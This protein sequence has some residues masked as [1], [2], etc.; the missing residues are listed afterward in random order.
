[1]H[2]KY[3]YYTKYI[4]KYLRIYKNR[5]TKHIYDTKELTIYSLKTV[6]YDTKIYKSI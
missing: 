5:K 4:Q 2:R 6:F 1:M 3:I